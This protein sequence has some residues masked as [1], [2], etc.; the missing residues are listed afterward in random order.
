MYRDAAHLENELVRSGALASLQYQI[1]IRQG[2]VWAQLQD[3]IR[4][5]T[6]DLVVIGTHG[7]LDMEKVLL[8]LVAEEIFRHA[9]WPVCG[10]GCPVLPI[11]SVL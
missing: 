10:A 1:V 9:K 7:R 8:G 6:I 3:I 2:Q 5:E 4:Q 11:S